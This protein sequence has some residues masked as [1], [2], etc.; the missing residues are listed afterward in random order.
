MKKALVVF[1]QNNFPQHVL[2]FANRMAREH[3]W[4]L[5][6]IF[7][8]DT[9]PSLYQPFPD[10][11]AMTGLPLTNESELARNEQVTFEN[12]QVFKDNCATAG[13]SCEV[14]KNITQEQL[15]DSSS[16]AA[17]IIMDA[18]IRFIQYSLT[19]VL[20]QTHCAICLVSATAAEPE[21]IV[22]A[23]DGS[24]AGAYAIRQFMAVFPKLNQLPTYLVSINP[25]L[26]VLEHKEFI[27]QTLPDHFPN[28]TLKML[29]GK[30]KEEMDNFVRQYPGALVVMGAFGRSALSRLFHPSLAK[31]VLE[32]TGA[33]V[34]IAHE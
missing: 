20:T 17:V 3:A 21:N 24:D 8:D 16:S 15:I 7:L 10:G 14:L 27:N 31:E 23:Y 19:D 29:R 12:L 6:G 30:V 33:T 4:L 32:E 25:D 2:A 22:L 11:V 18:R 26:E 28:Y 1:T 5:Y 9:P 13:I 34:F